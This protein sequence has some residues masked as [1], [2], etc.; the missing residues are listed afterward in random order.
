MHT[1]KP[2]MKKTFDDIRAGV[3]FLLVYSDK[4]RLPLELRWALKWVTTKVVSDNEI[5][6][7]GKQLKRDI[8]LFRR[9]SKW[10]S[11]LGYPGDF[12]FV[13]TKDRQLIMPTRLNYDKR[14]TSIVL[15]ESGAVD[16]LTSR[17]GVK[18]CELVNDSIYRMTEDKVDDMAQKVLEM[19]HKKTGTIPS[20][21]PVF[22]SIL[23]PDL[24]FLKELKEW[25]RG[26]IDIDQMRWEAFPSDDLIPGT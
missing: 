2:K 1:Y 9:D 24:A 26:S 14:R 11:K 3:V 8:K 4:D 13:K 20:Y 21:V 25:F 5:E 18:F 7:R 19:Y 6:V 12:T 15:N 22:N 17:T 16:F 10:V 23:S